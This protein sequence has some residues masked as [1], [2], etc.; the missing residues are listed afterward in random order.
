MPK[1]DKIFF[2]L[3]VLRKR[4]S[5]V[6]FN[7]TCCSCLS[8]DV[9]MTVLNVYGTNCM[10]MFFPRQA[11]LLISAKWFGLYSCDHVLCRLYHVLL[12]H[13]TF[14][15]LDFQMKW[16]FSLIEEYDL[17]KCKPHNFQ[18]EMFQYKIR[19]FTVVFFFFLHLTFCEFWLISSVT[20]NWLIKVEVLKSIEHR[21]NIPVLI[22]KGFVDLENFHDLDR[23]YSSDLLLV[24]GNSELDRFLW[25]V[26]Y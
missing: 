7:M 22:G 19:S 25:A 6:S 5:W 18:W 23:E 2:S 13:E 9:K 8:Y 15:A 12:F 1:K 17:K 4:F 24:K 10:K 3:K 16:P 14:S 11:F 21:L 20:R 26:M